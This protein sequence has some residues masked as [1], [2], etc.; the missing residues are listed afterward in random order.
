MPRLLSELRRGTPHAARWCRPG[1]AATMSMVRNSESVDVSCLEDDTCPPNKLDASQNCSKALSFPHKS[2]MYL[3]ICILSEWKKGQK[4]IN[5]TDTG[6][7]PFSP[8]VHSL[9]SEMSP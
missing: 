7:C 9:V 6:R 1:K 5:A 2:S 4:Y 3:F 8:M